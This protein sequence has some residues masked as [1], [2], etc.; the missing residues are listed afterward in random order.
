MGERNNIFLVNDGI[1]FYSH[2]DT[3]GKL[4]RILQKALIRGQDRWKDPSYLNK[5]IFSEMIKDEVE[6]L[7]GYGLSSEMGDGQVVLHVDIEKQEVDGVAFS[8]F[9]K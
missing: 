2:W 6:G 7:T 5:I 9:I 3:V 8:K 4:K 1:Y